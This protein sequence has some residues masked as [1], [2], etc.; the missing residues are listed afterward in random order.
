MNFLQSV[1]A[2]IKRHVTEIHHH[3]LVKSTDEVLKV[4]NT[5]PIAVVFV[6]LSLMVSKRTRKSV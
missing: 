6:P 1:G 5:N 3:S 4:R 2:W